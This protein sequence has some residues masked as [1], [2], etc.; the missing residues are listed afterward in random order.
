MLSAVISVALCVQLIAGAAVETKPNI[1]MILTDDQDITLDS[2]E[3]MSQTKKL[4]VDQGI[5]MQYHL[6]C[7][8]KL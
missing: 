1:V 2:M 3:A 4:I 7:T 8:L 5:R 6:H